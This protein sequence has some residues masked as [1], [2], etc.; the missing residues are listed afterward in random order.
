MS[1]N[2]EEFPD[3]KIQETFS[4]IDT[5]GKLIALKTVEV[6]TSN[7]G[8]CYFHDK[9]T[10]KITCIDKDY[11]IGHCSGEFRIDGK[12]VIFLDVKNIP[13][14]KK[15]IDNFGKPKGSIMKNETVSEG[16]LKSFLTAALLAAA[17]LEGAIPTV[18]NDILDSI[19]QVES[20]KRNGLKVKDTNGL[21]SYGMF[22]IQEPYLKDANR[23]LKT[24]YTL[25]D[26]RT[27][28]EI[29]KK[30]VKAYLTNYAKNYKRIKGKVPTVKQM[31]AMHNGGPTG[32]R[33][34]AALKYA[35][36]VLN[37]LNESIT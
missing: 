22:Q 8:D 19:A 14:L 4:V 24:K 15:Q 26:V 33:K 9:K 34:E 2:L 28:P 27:N 18:T 31:I 6:L 25:E 1:K 32:Y 10:G 16:K 17:P 20:N 5:H 35:D 13:E 7:C 12:N 11:K 30:V 3:K 21:Y 23:I 37:K 36:K 29:S